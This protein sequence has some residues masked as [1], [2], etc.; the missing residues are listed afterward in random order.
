MAAAAA[1]VASAIGRVGPVQATDGDTVHVGDQ[2]TATTETKITNTAGGTAIR[3][4]AAGGSPGIRGD[5]DTDAGVTGFGA[6]GLY[7]G[8]GTRGVVGVSNGDYGVVGTSQVDAT[9]VLGYSGLQGTEP[10]AKAKT[11]LYGYAAQDSTS[12][13]VWGQ[14]PAGRAVRGSTTTGYAGYFEGKVYSTKWFELKEISAPAAPTTNRARLFIR[15]NGSGKTQ[16][17][18]KFANGPAKVLATQS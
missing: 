1:T 12:T 11:G 6:L 17:C 8:G 3:G 16:L 4:V 10:A 13:A 5:S 9:G 2:L 14:S 7:G 18:I 15:D